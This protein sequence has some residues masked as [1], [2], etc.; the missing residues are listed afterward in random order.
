MS[1]GNSVA[2]SAIEAEGQAERPAF[3][4]PADMATRYTV[5]VVETPEGGDRRLGMFLAGDRDNPSLE[6]AN[7]RIVARNEDPETVATL[8]K[9][10]QH[11]GWDKI[12]VRGSPEFT[13]AVWEAG[14]RA[15]LSVSGYEPTF[16][17]AERMESLR[18]ADAERADRLLR[19]EAGRRADVERTAAARNE[20]AADREDA[21]V[22]V[23]IAVE[24]ARSDRAVERE[25]VRTEHLREEAAERRHDSGELAELFLHGAAE[26]IAAEPRLANAVQAQAT[27]EQHIAEVFKGDAPQIASETHDSRQMISDVLRRGLDVSVREPTPVRQIEPVQSP[28]ELER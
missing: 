17:D 19:Q 16:A 22:A 18:R 6:I 3:D 14:S 25:E 28:P 1:E 13:K 21:A 23:S 26:S 4:I 15:G 11:N 10:A 2:P 5:R 9:L 27:M 8:V 24:E 12:D 7:D 20:Q